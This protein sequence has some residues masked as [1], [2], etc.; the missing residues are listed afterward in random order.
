MWGHGGNAEVGTLGT[1][2]SVVLFYE[3][4]QLLAMD[5]IRMIRDWMAYRKPKKLQFNMTFLDSVEQFYR[6]AG[7]VTFAQKRALENIIKK[8]RMR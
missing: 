4:S 1:Q 6:R 7:F 3:K 5:E 8:F 2:N